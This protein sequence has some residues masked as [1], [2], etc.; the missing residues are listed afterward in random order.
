[1]NRMWSNRICRSFIVLSMSLFSAQ[2][3][4]SLTVLNFE[5]G[6]GIMGYPNNG[7]VLIDGE[8]TETVIP[9]DPPTGIA[10]INRQAGDNDE[11][12]NFSNIDV[13]VTSRVAV[14]KGFDFIIIQPDTTF[15][16]ILIT[17]DDLSIDSSGSLGPAKVDAFIEFEMIFEIDG[18]YDL[19][20]AWS[21]PSASVPVDLLQKV[22]VESL[23]GSNQ[24]D[25]VIYDY[26]NASSGIGTT[27]YSE[28]RELQSGRYKITSRLA[29][30]ESGAS[31]VT[32]DPVTLDFSPSIAAV[33][34]PSSIMF[35]FL[36]SFPLIIRRSR[37]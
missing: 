15:D 18:A 14:N 6:V 37:A 10:W 11:S 34:E 13:D 21:D 8:G 22:T 24:V 1:M 5:L 3:H 32:A 30:T 19:D 27:D 20:M 33:P 36:G 23:D 12:F 26:S 7:V 31:V 35:I 9:S 16:D 2:A 28:Q 25:S 4:A 17:L 29:L